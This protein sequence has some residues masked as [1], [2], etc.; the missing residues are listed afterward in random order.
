MKSADDTRNLKKKAVFP[1]IDDSI[2]KREKYK[3]IYLIK[4]LKLNTYN[5][6]S[7]Y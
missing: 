5:L 3:Y 7:F 1:D 4:Q 6:E 2:F